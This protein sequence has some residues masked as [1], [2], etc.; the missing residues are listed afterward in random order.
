MSI[1][2]ALWHSTYCAKHQDE[3]LYHNRHRLE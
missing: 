3:V 2:L 1:D